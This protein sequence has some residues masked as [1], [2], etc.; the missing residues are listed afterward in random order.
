MILNILILINVMNRPIFTAEQV[1][2]NL[3]A[4]LPTIGTVQYK[5]T[6]DMKILFGD[7]DYFQSILNFLLDLLG[8]LVEFTIRERH[9]FWENC[10]VFFNCDVVGDL[11]KWKSGFGFLLPHHDQDYLIPPLD[12]FF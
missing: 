6:S 10:T 12:V 5:N 8:V 4:F 2:N 1:H 3:I 11:F 7:I 9:S